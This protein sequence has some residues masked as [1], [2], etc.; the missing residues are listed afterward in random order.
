MTTGKDSFRA[1]GASSKRNVSVK[2][3]VRVA[4]NGE[5]K[6]VVP[7]FEA[8]QKKLR[9]F[10]DTSMIQTI[11]ATSA[12][13]P[14]LG[15]CW[16]VNRH[17][18]AP[19][20]EVLLE[21]THRDPDAVFGEETEYFMLIMDPNAP[22]YQLRLDLPRHHLSAVPHVFFTGRFEIVKADEQ[23]EHPEIWKDYFHL[24]DPDLEACDLM[25]FNQDERYFF[26]TELEARVKAT[27]KAKTRIT[28]DGKKMLKIRRGRRIKTK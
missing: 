16:Y 23:L 28:S 12:H 24:D 11:P 5:G 15:G 20:T 9:E 10:R 19:H 3:W 17:E 8:F 1:Q 6:Q 27:V 26:A 21:Y 13:G 22:L 18:L 4:D 14:E 25:D 7:I 2:S